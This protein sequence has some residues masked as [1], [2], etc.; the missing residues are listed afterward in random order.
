MM[1]REKQKKPKC[2]NVNDDWEKIKEDVSHLLM[3]EYIRTCV[4][5]CTLTHL[6]P[7]ERQSVVRLF[8]F[9]HFSPVS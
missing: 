7:S 8:G 5:K 4:N 3:L 1:L 9:A 2:L 6:I